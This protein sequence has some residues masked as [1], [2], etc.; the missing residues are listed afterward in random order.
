[1]YNSVWSFLN[2]ASAS[3]VIN[4]SGNSQPETV[5]NSLNDYYNLSSIETTNKEISQILKET[6]YNHNNETF[7]NSDNFQEKEKEQPPIKV[8]LIRK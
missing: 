6:N 3:I 8:G 7:N 5:T 1:M 2:P 4:I